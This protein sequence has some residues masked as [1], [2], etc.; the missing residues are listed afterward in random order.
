LHLVGCLYSCFDDARP[1]K[2]QNQ[3]V[4]VTEGHNQLFIVRTMEYIRD[5]RRPPRCELDLRSYGIIRR[6][7]TSNFKTARITCVIHT[8]LNKLRELNANY[9]RVKAEGTQ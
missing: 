3:S 5:F 1:H 6:N 9:L 4:S 7:S 2:R 8:G